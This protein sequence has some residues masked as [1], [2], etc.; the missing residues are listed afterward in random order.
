MRYLLE[1]KHECLFAPDY[2]GT[3]ALM[4]VCRATDVEEAKERLP[5]FE[6][7]LEVDDDVNATN[8]E[9]WSA[10]MFACQANNLAFVS[11]LLDDSADIHQRDKRGRS[12]IHHAARFG[13]QWLCE[14]LIRRGA[15]VN[16]ADHDGRTP[17]MVASTDAGGATTEET[18]CLKA[19]CLLDAGAGVNVLDK[20][21]ET[22]LFFACRS[23]FCQT[24]KML[25]NAGA[26]VGITNWRGRTASHYARNWL[27]MPP[28]RTLLAD[29]LCAEEQARRQA[30]GTFDLAGRARVP[31]ECTDHAVFVVDRRDE[32]EKAA[33]LSAPVLHET[34][35]A[36]LPDPSAPAWPPDEEFACRADDDS[37]YDA[38]GEADGADNPVFVTA[39][40]SND[41]DPSP[42]E[43]STPS[44]MRDDAVSIVVDGESMSTHAATTPT[45]D[46]DP[47]VPMF[48]SSAPTRGCDVHDGDRDR[49]SNED[50]DQPGCEADDELV[51]RCITMAA[52]GDDDD[53]SQPTSD[54]YPSMCEREAD[55]DE[56]SAIVALALTG[57]ETSAPPEPSAP[58][59]IDDV[60]TLHG[61]ARHAPARSVVGLQDGVPDYPNDATRAL[62]SLG[63]DPEI[64]RERSAHAVAARVQALIAAGGDIHFEH[65]D[66]Q[67]AL[68]HACR[69]PNTDVLL[70]GALIEAGSD[71]DLLG[72]SGRTL[73]HHAAA[74]GRAGLIPLLAEHCSSINA[75]DEDGF[76]PL[77]WARR[78]GHELCAQAL[79]SAGATR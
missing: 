24:N 7:I 10:L 45:Y 44:S 40:H 17:L 71:A 62:F 59:L 76:T 49:S 2:K 56:V 61:S 39:A 8:N 75:Q 15:N 28:G 38:D 47:T 12:A 64:I 6:S 51:K 70:A 35:H 41:E 48:Q 23:G 42:I 58:P 18:W 68:W 20:N 55:G 13:S 31:D 30:A 57:A 9:G 22:A 3:T 29:L 34:E 37:A 11:R 74:T 78:R 36:S 50:D 65:R 27:S 33:V 52:I 77:E 1:T 72:P 19:K 4:L 43:I 67:N 16:C 46:E 14:H 26:D 79:L 54:T 53:P 25:I 32:S 63:N 21:G 60:G 73:L 5:I 69:H 66:Y